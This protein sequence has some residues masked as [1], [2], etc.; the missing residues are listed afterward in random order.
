MNRI[1][2]LA[3]GNPLRSDDGIGWHACDEL[4]QKLVREGIEIL[5]L[6]Q[7]T[8]EIAERI[9]WEDGVI[10]VDAAESGHP[11]EV[12]CMPVNPSSERAR[13]SHQLTPVE[14]LTLARE[15]YGANPRAYV[16]T[17]SGERFG[18]GTELSD[19]VADA[20][21]CLLA[22]VDRLVRELQAAQVTEPLAH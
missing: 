6:H 2:I 7:L 4:K 5:C 10:F 20:M 19:A 12:R 3:Y 16:V 1:L 17:L 15:L 18:H 22:E 21:P 8:P 11:G 13:F 9:S 14:I